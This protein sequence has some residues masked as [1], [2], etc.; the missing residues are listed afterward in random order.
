M[1][2]RGGEIIMVIMV[3]AETCCQMPVS[4]KQVLHESEGASYVCLKSQM[5]SIY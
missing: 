4:D 5:V 2:E 3:R 1:L